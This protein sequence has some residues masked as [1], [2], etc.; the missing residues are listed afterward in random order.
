ME[1][2]I[3]VQKV[4]S[5]DN[6]RLI[7]EGV[8]DGLAVVGEGFTSRLATAKS[9]A[10]K[11]RYVQGLLL[12]AKPATAMDLQAVKSAR[13]RSIT[14]RSILWLRVNWLLIATN[15]GIAYLIHHFCR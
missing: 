12:A 7:A 10:H 3:Q 13:W 9:E 14:G 5:P 11:S 6:K 2:T 1:H 4:Y 8:V 15:A